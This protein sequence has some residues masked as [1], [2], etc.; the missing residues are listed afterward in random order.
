MDWNDFTSGGVGAV[1]GS[2]IT[3]VGFRGRLNNLEKECGLLR[4][5]CK[6]LWKE[7][8]A[9]REECKDV[10]KETLGMFGTIQGDIKGLIAK[11]AQRRKG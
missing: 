2:I 4:E 9:L 3:I 1:C 8:K 7:C 5:E 10:R 11:A 6:T